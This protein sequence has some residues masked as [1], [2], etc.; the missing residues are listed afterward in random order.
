[1][2]FISLPQWLYP[3]S[4]RISDSVWCVVRVFRYISCLSLRNV[5]F[6]CPPRLTPAPVRRL[7]R[8]LSDLPRINRQSSQQPHNCAPRSQCSLCFKSGRIIHWDSQRAAGLLKPT[9]RWVEA[10]A[11]NTHNALFCFFFSNSSSLTSPFFPHDLND[12]CSFYVCFWLPLHL[13]I[14][15]THSRFNLLVLMTV[16]SAPALYY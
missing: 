8:R 11:M 3:L 13:S 5:I 10:R 14:R 12:F 9:D 15:V 16:W 7:T 1:M 2:Y 6:I 4:L